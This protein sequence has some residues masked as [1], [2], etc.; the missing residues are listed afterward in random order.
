MDEWVQR[1]IDKWP[2]VPSLFGWLGLD[3]RGQWLIQ[4]EPV[5]HP[6]I[7]DTMAR[8]YDCDAH[9]RWYFQN[10]PQ[11]GYVALEYTPFVGR[12]QSDDRLITHTGRALET[13]TA[14]YLDEHSN[15]VVDTPDG[16]TLVQ[17]ADL[18]WVL[19][20]LRRNGAEIDDESLAAALAQPSGSATELMFLFD[21]APRP[22]HR[23]DVADMPATLGFVRD[24]EPREGEK[25]N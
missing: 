12:V 1:A 18:A 11:R 4:G 22:V 14:L 8:N 3:R 25:H 23:C 19:E 10:G 21:G 6:R 13:I 9:G 15:A 2:D 7:A 20:R 24:P 5:T 16:A 17:G